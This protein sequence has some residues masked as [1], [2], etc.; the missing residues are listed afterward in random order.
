MKEMKYKTA[1]ENELLNKIFEFLVSSGL[2]N[3][4]V[5]E[6]SKKTGIAQGSLYYRFPDKASI[7]C[8]ATKHGLKKV[9]DEIFGYV[10]SSINDLPSFFENCLDKI[11]KYRRELRF[12]YQMASSPIYGEKIRKDGK[13][14]KKMYDKYAERLA[15]ILNCDLEK[16][17]PIVYLFVSA[18]CDYAIWEDRANT[19][20][21]IDFIYSILPD[22]I[23]T[24]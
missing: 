13:Y 15:E 3:I 2:E 16:L 22:V 14:F 24:I 4:S 10:F 9:T 1:D 17:K 12:I 6:L 20:T 11:G 7:I 19:Q 21:E 5:R 18:I 23:N 8:E